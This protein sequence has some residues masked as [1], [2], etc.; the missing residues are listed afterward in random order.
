MVTLKE[1]NGKNRYDLFKQLCL[2]RS[3]LVDIIDADSRVELFN[4]AEEEIELL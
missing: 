3:W 1:M 4:K 2:G